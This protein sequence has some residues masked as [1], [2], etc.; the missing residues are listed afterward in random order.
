MRTDREWVWL[1]GLIVFVG[2]PVLFFFAMGSLP[3]TV[4]PVEFHVADD[5]PLTGV[6]VRIDRLDP[7]DPGASGSTVER[8]SIEKGVHVVVYRTRT[9][10]AY[11]VQLVEDGDACTRVVRIRRGEDALEPTVRRPADG[12]GDCPVSF[13]VESR[14]RD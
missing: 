10:G 11:E 8:R 7:D 5:E 2:A 6:D 13:F 4:E 9:V 3:G 1:A 14:S 12:G